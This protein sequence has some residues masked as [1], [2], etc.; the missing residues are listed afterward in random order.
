[1]R[2]VNDG[3][4]MMIYKKIPEQYKNMLSVFYS[5]IEGNATKPDNISVLIKNF[6]PEINVE[7]KN[8]FDYSKK[9]LNNIIKTIENNIKVMLK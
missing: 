4:G 1:M 6:M 7:D 2:N 9:I 3:N 5:A 8:N